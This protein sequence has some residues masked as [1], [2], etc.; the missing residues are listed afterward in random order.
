VAA[1]EPLGNA[2]LARPVTIDLAWVRMQHGLKEGNA[3]QTDLHLVKWL[4][5]Y[6]TTA[7]R[8]GVFQVARVL[9]YR[10]CKRAGVYRLLLPSRKAVPLEFRSD[11]SHDAAQAFAPW[12]ERSVLTE[13]DELLRG[14][15][16]FFSAHAQEIGNPP[17]W[18]LN[19][20]ERKRHP[21]SARH[22]SEIADFSAEAG[23]IKVIWE[24]SRFSWAPVL[25]RAWRIGGDARYLSTLQMWMQDWRR[26]NPP[27][28]GPNWMCGQ[29]TSIRLI[30]ALLALRLAGLEKNAGPGMVAFIAAHCRRVERTTFYAIAQDNNHATSEAAGLFVGGTWLAQHGRDGEKDR[31][32]RWAEKGRKMLESMVSRLVF[33]DGSFSQHSLTYH[34]MMLDTLSIAEAWRRNAGGAPFAAEFYA[35]AAAATRWLGAMIDPAN[36]D[37]PNLGGNDGAH[38]YRLDGSAYRD[39]RSSLQ[40]ASLLFIGRAALPSGP[41][42]EPAAWLGV[43]SESSERP[44]MDDLTSAVFPDG[45]YVILRNRSGVRV[46]LRA[47]TARFRPAH[48][49]A[50]HLD[51][52][53]K[54]KNL[55]RDGGTYA[56]AGGGA[57][58]QELASVAGH[59]AQEFDGHDQMPRLGRFLYGGWVR[60]AG[61]PA[62]AT[63]AAG[64]SWTGS[65]TDVWGAQHERSVTLGEDVLSVRDHVQGFKRAAVLRWRLAPG[66]WSQNETGCAS[67]LARLQVDSSVPIRRMSLESG[68]ESR[69]Y[70]EKSAVPVLEVGVA[71]SPAVLTTTISLS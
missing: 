59:N 57:M 23:D 43:S 11:S 61:E 42:D 24:M 70:L 20:F 7:L 38:S 54:G 64:Q 16:N 9:L 52:W 60:V 28:T 5:I 65:Y 67:T 10:M 18:F 1:R 32:R 21:Q 8:L 63:S 29:E 50:L 41:W 37:G 66:N 30:N 13:A 49:D 3:L 56:Y 25:A 47:P 62:I 19:P 40:L 17:D 48:A 55:L 4:K 14:R 22:W 34:R 45:G 44:W 2:R 68:W 27:N 46:L 36:G 39:F 6:F 15:M 33:P 53:W 26:C 69:H 12:A 51:L 31:G 58:G 35:R 71:Q